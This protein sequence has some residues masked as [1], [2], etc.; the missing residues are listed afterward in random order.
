MT[1]STTPRKQRADCAAALPIC[2]RVRP[3]HGE[4]ACAAL[5]HSTSSL[6]SPMA[7][8]PHASRPRPGERSLK[9]ALSGIPIHRTIES[10]DES[11]G[12]RG[13]E[14][15]TPRNG[16]GVMLSSRFHC[17]FAVGRSPFRTMCSWVVGLSTD[18]TYLIFSWALPLPVT[19]RSDFLSVSA[20][21]W[22]SCCC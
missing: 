19:A 10:Y 18:R 7:F 8:T 9:R 16:P 11:Y 5:L 20:T 2:T 22:M 1:G 17:Y 21:R 12:D 6:L 4:C 14:S 13:L 15:V 3:V